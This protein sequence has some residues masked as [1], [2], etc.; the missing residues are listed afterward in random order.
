MANGMINKSINMFLTFS[1]KM[2]LHSL[3]G[4]C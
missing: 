1:E 4:H 3:V 2:I